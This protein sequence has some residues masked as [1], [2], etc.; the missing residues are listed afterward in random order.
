MAPI[1]DRA[2]FEKCK[3]TF[4]ESRTAWGIDWIWV[5]TV[6]GEAPATDRVGILDAAAVTHTRKQD[7]G[8]SFYAGL[9]VDPVEE[10]GALLKRHG[11]A[12]K[13][14]DVRSFLSHRL[15]L[16]FFGTVVTVPGFHRLRYAIWRLYFEASQRVPA[17]RRLGRA[18][19]AVVFGRKGDPTIL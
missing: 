9:G 6:N 16:A 2:T 14:K 7:L 19:Q 8:A 1:F 12:E 15:E 11:L 18:F 3:W 4:S 5:E 13:P 17:I 10:M